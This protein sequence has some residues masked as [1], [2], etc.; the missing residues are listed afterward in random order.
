MFDG[1]DV[2]VG[3]VIGICNGR[4]TEVGGVDGMYGHVRSG[5]QGIGIDSSFPD[6]F[7][8]A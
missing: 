4:V 7:A 2:D 3:G 6:P 5:I 1:V 8:L